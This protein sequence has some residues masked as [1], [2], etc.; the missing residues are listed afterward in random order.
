MDYSDDYLRA[1]LPGDDPPV[2]LVPADVSRE[3]AGWIER[4]ELADPA[5][6]A[7]SVRWTYAIF[8]ELALGNYRLGRNLPPW[9]SFLALASMASP[10][11]P[12]ITVGLYDPAVEMPGFGL[13]VNVP[14]WDGPPFLVLDEL[15]FPH[16]GRRF[17]LA[18]RQVV[19]ELHAALSPAPNPPP[20]PAP[21]PAPSPA[22]ATAACWARCNLAGDWGVVTAGHAVGSSQPGFSVPLATGGTGRL[23]R[24]FWQPVDAA[25]VLT[26][27]PEV[28]PSPLAVCHFPA[29]G[30]PVAV[31]TR[32]GRLS[33]TVASA[34]NSLGFYRTRLYPVL[35]FLDKPCVPGDSGAL[36]RLT[37]GE[38]VG[39]YSGSQPSPATGGNSGRVLNFAQAMFALDTSAYL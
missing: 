16:L 28:L 8:S 13:A 23:A 9:D 36:V 14:E 37:S 32:S 17:P 34:C 29:A 39:L 35:F 25:F 38:A 15:F 19:T 24:S 7:R 30:L 12:R 5:L 26:D 31:E 10:A 21:T 1:R 18:L 27:P 20:T 4:G 2:A 22:N 33:R 11:V 3:I 6:V